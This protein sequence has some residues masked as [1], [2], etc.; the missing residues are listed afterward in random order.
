MRSID[1]IIVHCSYTPPSMNIGAAEIRRWHVEERDWA[2]IGYHYVIRRD[3]ACEPGRPIEK[4]GAH[5]KGHNGGSIGVCLVGGM[6]E[7]DRRP[8]CNFTCSQWASLR[9]LVRELMEL[10]DIDVARIIGHRDVNAGKACPTF[11]VPAWA[12]TLPES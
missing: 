6:A 7:G 11:D 12:A 4:N 3:G 8:D 10:Y 5:A 1:T 9:L 2:D